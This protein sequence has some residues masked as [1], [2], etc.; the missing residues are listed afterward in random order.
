M[1]LASFPKSLFAT[2]LGIVLT[3]SAFSMPSMANRD[4]SNARQG[5]PGRRISGGVRE[6]NCFRDFDQS[7]VA[8]M[9]RNN[10]GKTAEAHPTFWFSVPATTRAKEVEF[11]LFNE[12]DEVVYSTLIRG[13]VEQGLSEFQLPESV[14]GLSVDKMYRWTL[15]I[16]CTDSSRFVVQGWVH[17]VAMPR[18]FEQ[19]IATASPE[20]KITLYGS[21]GLWHEQ[22]TALVDLR[23]SNLTDVD[24]QMEWAELLAATGLT[25][26]VSSNI[27]ETMKALEVSPLSVGD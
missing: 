20:E 4:T 16:G 10:L 1:Q 18:S 12:S 22:V 8:I 11:Q 27:T 5:L 6:G 17:R 19:Q 3:A 26:H 15:S 14:T 23:R 24:F 25:S 2:T 13:S 9:P 7:L 21:A